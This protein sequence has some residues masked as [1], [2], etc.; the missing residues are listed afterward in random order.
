V[1]PKR[2]GFQN[3]KTEHDHRE[4]ITE[5]ENQRKNKT[6]TGTG[7][8]ETP[9]PDVRNSHKTNFRRRKLRRNRDGSN[10]DQKRTP[11]TAKYR[12][13]EAN[14]SFNGASTTTTPV[15]HTTSVTDR[16]RR[17]SETAP[18]NPTLLHLDELSPPLRES[19]PE[20]NKNAIRRKTE[21]ESHRKSTPAP[22]R[23]GGAEG[24]LLL[25]AP[26]PPILT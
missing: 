17:R 23:N 20:Q 24:W 26:P 7:E 16:K 25:V 13:G 18:K 8:Q 11:H 19:R 21:P 2:I 12:S 9:A 3:D 22:V 10:H 14:P 5:L 15:S 1:A 4:V 6:R